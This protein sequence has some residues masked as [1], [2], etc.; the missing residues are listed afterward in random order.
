MAKKD[1]SLDWD[2]ETEITGNRQRTWQGKRKSK[3]RAA[4]RKAGGRGMSLAQLEKQAMRQ[5]PGIAMG[6]MPLSHGAEIARGQMANKLMKGG[7]GIRLPQMG[8]GGMKALL[9]LLLLTMLMGGTGGGNEDL[10]GMLG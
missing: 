1:P 8:K 7:G 10:D 9:P 2:L 4:A 6:E 3:R 5:A